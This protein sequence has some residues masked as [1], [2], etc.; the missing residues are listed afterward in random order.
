MYVRTRMTLLS[1]GFS[2][3]VQS[4]DGTNAYEL[5]SVSPSLLMMRNGQVININVEGL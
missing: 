1:P 4:A 5:P 2:S 3:K